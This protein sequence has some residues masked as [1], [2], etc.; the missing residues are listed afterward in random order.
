MGEEDT[1]YAVGLCFVE[2]SEDERLL[3][4]EV[5]DDPQQE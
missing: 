2:I 3:F 5:L 1:T 4:Q